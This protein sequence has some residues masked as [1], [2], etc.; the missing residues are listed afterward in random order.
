MWVKPEIFK[1]PRMFKPKSALVRQTSKFLG[2]LLLGSALTAVAPMAANA[3]TTVLLSE[4]DALAF[5][6]AVV[7]NIKGTGT[8]AGDI[9]LYRNVGSFSGTSVDAVVTTVSIPSGSISNYDN[10]GSAS[11]A[12]GYQKNFQLNTT[13]GSVQM[14]FDFYL[15]GTYTVV[16]SGTPVILQNV[17]IS[18][19]DLDTSSASGSY[20]YSDFTGFQTY[21][22][23]TDTNLVV[24]PLASG[25]GARFQAGKTGSRS[26][27]PQ[28]QVLIKYT[29]VQTLKVTFGNVVT[30]ST[31]YFGLVFGGWQGGGT[32]D[33][34]P[35]V[36]NTPPTTT[37]VSQRV[38]ATGSLQTIPL[39]SFGI[40]A[41]VDNN[42]FVNVK[43]AT[44]PSLGTLSLSGVNVTA[45][46]VISTVDIDA[47]RLKYTTSG[48]AADQTVTF[49]VYDGAD[50]S[51]SSYTLTLKPATNNQVITFGGPA[52]Q[53]PGITL[54]SGAVTSATGL[55]VTLTSLTPGICTVSGLDINT[56]ANGTCTIVATQ[57]G[58]ATYAAAVPVT[59]SFLVASGTSQVITF[60]QPSS[61]TTGAT[62]TSG[63]VT[64]ASGLTVILTSLTPSVC[65]VSG[66]NIIT[67]TAGTCTITAS[68]PGNSTY[69][70]ATNVTRSFTV[71]APTS[72]AVTIGVRTSGVGLTYSGT[73]TRSAT[74]NTLLNGRIDLND[75]AVTYQFCYTRAS[76]TS[77][78]VL[79]GSSS[80][81]V[82]CV[83]A[84]SSGSSTDIPTGKTMDIPVTS[85]ALTSLS[86]GKYYYYQ[87]VGWVT[88][89]S[90]K[91]YGNIVRWKTPSSS[92]SPT[93]QTNAATSLTTSGATLNGSVH[94]STVSNGDGVVTYC[95]SKTFTIDTTGAMTT[96][97]F[98]ISGTSVS[99]TP[100][101]V[102]RSNAITGLEAA[103][104]Y[105]YQII[106][107]EKSG[108]TSTKTYYA[109]IV[110]FTT[111][112]P[113]PSATTSAAT[114]ITNSTAV[115]NGSVLSY[116]TNTDTK[117]C[118]GT[119]APSASCTPDASLTTSPAII[120][121]TGSVLYSATVTGLTAG[122]TYY[123]RAVAARSTTN[124]V[125]SNV[126]TF[127]PGS[128][129]ATTLSP[130][131]VSVSGGGPSWKATLNG[132]VNSLGSTAEAFFCYSTSSSL[133][134]SGK[135][136][137]ASLTAATPSTTT[138]AEAVAT[139][140][141]TFTANTTYYYQVVARNQS[142][143]GL[144]NYGQVYSFITSTEPSVTTVA[145]TPIA[146]KTATI[147]GT[148]TP[149]SA[150][151][152]TS[153]CLSTSNATDPDSGILQSCIKTVIGSGSA[154]TGSSVATSNA[155]T[156]LTPGTTYY[157]QA[158][159]ENTRGTVYGSVLS[160]T[161]LTLPI[162]TTTAPTSITSSGATL[163]GKASAN[164]GTTT[165]VYFCL[166]TDPTVDQNGALTCSN[167]SPFSKS[168]SLTGGT[169]T[170]YTH[171]VS[172]L[173]S[174]TS[175][176]YQIYAT[177]SQG[178][179][180]GDV[181]SFIPGGAT[182]VTGSVTNIA[183][184]SVTL[185]GTANKQTDSGVNGY[186]C[187]SD[188]ATV[189]LDGALSCNIEKSSA[190]SIT[191]SGDVAMTLNTTALL[192]SG[193]T[194]YVQASVTGNAGTNFGAVVQF[195]T[196]PVVTFNSN[197]AD[198][199]T[200]MASQNVASGANVTLAANTYTRTRYT[201]AGWATS[202]TGAVARADG[203][204]FALT[205]SLTLYA[206]WTSTGYIVQF[207]NNAGTVQTM[208]DQTAT[209]ATN[210]TANTFTRT[211]YTFA[212]WSTVA[213]GSLA[214]SNQASYPF[215]EDTT[216]YARWT[217]NF[218]VV[219]F[220]ANGGTGTMAS[221][222]D[223]G[224]SVALSTN[225]F[226]RTNYTFAGWAT[227]SSGAVVYANGAN[228]DFTAIASTTLY[229]VWTSTSTIV[230]FYG[231]SGGSGSMEDQINAAVVSPN[232]SIALS[233]NI[234]TKP[235]STF[236]GWATSAASTSVVYSDG[237]L[238]DFSA[239]LT[240]Y[241]VWGSK[242]TYDANGGTGSVPVDST[243][244]LDGETATIKR[245]SAPDGSLSMTGFTVKGWAENAEG[246]GVIHAPASFVKPVEN[247]TLY[248][249]Y[250]AQITYA[251]TDS[252]GGSAPVDGTFYQ[253]DSPATI[254][255][256][257]TLVRTDWDFV[258]WFDGADT[259]VEG[260]D[261]LVTG[262]ITLQPVWS[263]N[264]KQWNA[265]YHSNIVG[266]GDELRTNRTLTTFA[267]IS[268]PFINS[269]YTFDGWTN[270]SG[271]D[272][273][274]P[275]Y[276]LYA[277]GTLVSVTSDPT[278]VEVWAC[279]SLTPAAGGGTVGGTPGG[280]TTTTKT[281]LPVFTGEV[282][283]IVPPKKI[284][285]NQLVPVTQTIRLVVPE[286]IKVE[287]VMV[288][289]KDVKA[290]VDEVTGAI[291]TNAIIGPKDKVTVSGTDVAGDQV[292]AQVALRLE[293]YSLA[294]VNFN[295][296]SAKLT[297]A[298]KAIIIKAAKVIKE[299]GF[300][301]I[302]LA[303]HTDVVG[304]Q[305]YDN[306]KLSDA[307][308]AAVAAFLKAQL[309]GTSIKVVT[310]GKAYK[311]L[312][313]S[314]TDATSNAVNRRVEIV[315]K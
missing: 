222:S 27:V 6:H 184:T 273:T 124:Y 207:K 119:T 65:T 100:T 132:Y 270:I 93:A 242:I 22:M 31:N 137:C 73:S 126:L 249:I 135:L 313:T 143:P 4:T 205:T 13:G 50:Y 215:T 62:V 267:L 264:T 70:P 86:T 174:G 113:N 301:E 89:S 227:S 11:T 210:L 247:L 96:C 238:Y 102:S 169:L 179:S 233:A 303:G 269:G 99:T 105:Y 305:V 2:V 300:T 152:T 216:L 40:F 262:S 41:D 72:G 224:A 246:T 101:Q 190:N 204:V 10:P 288:N 312:A 63:A 297:P 46:Q 21:T 240:L 23:T 170:T 188:S 203:A 80:Y 255:G 45:N 1:E 3:V 168:T 145:A 150:P 38:A 36:F 206:I 232:P 56:L 77:A 198:G 20:Q 54:S 134:A 148:F 78:G 164:N 294:N 9:V 160:F 298:A 296:A 182:A 283:N 144:I 196:N 28:D 76:N 295:T 81:S 178:N 156:G 167:S 287:T 109:N 98:T 110:N 200:A 34:K 185:N 253:K 149:N 186:L 220:V 278:N 16:G 114:S 17:K 263:T 234:F 302:N 91:V 61:Q 92:S 217:A 44:L 84:S 19:I 87:V 290:T 37:S 229:A 66:L 159:A 94:V 213:N 90:T 308:S 194:Y 82:T 128:P 142:L 158:S 226:T 64:N 307:R 133:D 57:A 221:Q 151:T 304:G 261:F 199:G 55:T 291:K 67:L 236:K 189:N 141:T 115:L 85:R 271:C 208:A 39:S 172:S 42:P 239:N 202:P 35:N 60:N 306:Q 59:Q 107:V 258:G 259:Y 175:Y 281:K 140:P 257:G 285:V 315:V 49:Y 165:S 214:Y 69:S 192:T 248:A 52:T 163:N 79:V 235:G 131:A 266:V 129:L 166:A 116:N 95:V 245:G 53:V 88:G 162:A 118:W 139:T 161:T 284:A 47:G 58:D 280:T 260:Q 146:A 32:P 51:T 209:T 26:A 230:K 243:I 187:I 250:A 231:G 292:S 120:K 277:A 121:S 71:N 29:T 211:N 293:T 176:Y 237:A 252:T 219:Q 136:G 112:N 183:A 289:G 122:T 171:S 33:E 111:S 276:E 212:G 173:N 157:F 309:K 106:I 154:T 125:A 241:A 299:H 268:N 127:T 310:S 83:N 193:T 223:N 274:D 177:N 181:F 130:T 155:L 195:T 75:N 228:F 104:V 7:T 5:D 225:T 74:I 48:L 30:G 265:T 153:F 254:L 12:T 147:K 180:Y 14:Q 311:E 18:S 191:T 123:F 138:S 25:A 8:A 117:F 103:T 24:T 275:D 97:D 43:I 272:K 201:F 314:K 197:G 286:V 15:S 279:W 68:Q 244:Y 251:T 282:V 256:A 218:N 108:S